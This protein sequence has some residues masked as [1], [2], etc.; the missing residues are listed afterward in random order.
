[1]G[2]E[3]YR[4]QILVRLHSGRVFYSDPEPPSNW[5]V[6]RPYCHGKKF[7]L[8]DS[9]T[10]P[11]PTREHRCVTDDYGAVRVRAWGELHPK[12]PEVKWEA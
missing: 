4:A 11:G 9:G 5:P 8:K 1:M 10:W 7:D 6:G 3:G 2:L 12:I